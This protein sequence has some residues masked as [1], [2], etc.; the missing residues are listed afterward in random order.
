[1]N[2][3]FFAMRMKPDLFRWMEKY[4][5]ANSL[6]MSGAVN[7]AIVEFMGKTEAVKEAKEQNDIEILRS[8]IG[9]TFRFTKTENG[10]ALERVIANVVTLGDNR[11]GEGN[12]RQS[13]TA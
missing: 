12:A 7:Q 8:N 1:M 9:D 2:T 11:E 13:K 10:F 6:S 4:A 3:H 5:K